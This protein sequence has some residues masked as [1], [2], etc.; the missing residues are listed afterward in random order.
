MSEYVA[1]SLYLNGATGCNIGCKTLSSGRSLLPLKLT[2]PA[3]TFICPATL[4]NKGEIGLCP[5]HYLPAGS[6]R[7]GVATVH[8][9]SN[10][11][12]SDYM[13]HR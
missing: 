13:S 12:A 5:K 8:A 11:A 9:S 1:C 3:G 2:C 10:F 7:Q 4:L 6:S